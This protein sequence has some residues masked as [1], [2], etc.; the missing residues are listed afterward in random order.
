MEIICIILGFLLIIIGFIGI[1]APILPATAASFAAILLIHFSKVYEF[2]LLTLMILS[3][4]TILTFL[5]DYIMPVIGTK[6]FGGTKYGV[7]GS[8]I[9]IFIS[10][11]IVA[12]M[13]IF[14]IVGILFLA[15]IG[16]Y[17]GELIGGR[18]NG[19]AIYAATGAMLGFLFSTFAKFI[20]CAIITV[21][22]LLAL[23]CHFK[24]DFLCDKFLFL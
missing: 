1:I 21:V 7:I 15:F 8:S 12:P 6:K 22:F 14:A 17:L 16:A 23:A 13:G 2:H 19:E 3:A 9:G 5:V 20:V 10:M 4:L 24:I 18:P 11:F